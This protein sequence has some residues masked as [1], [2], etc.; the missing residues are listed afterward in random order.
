[1][2]GFSPCRL[3]NHIDEALLNGI[4]TSC[5]FLFVSLAYSFLYLSVIEF[6]L[7]CVPSFLCAFFFVCLSVS[8]EYRIDSAERIT[9]FLFVSCC[10]SPLE[11]QWVKS[12]LCVYS[13]GNPRSAL[14]VH[15][16]IQ[17]PLGVSIDRKYLT[18]P[19]SLINE[20]TELIKCT[21][22]PP[23]PAPLCPQT[24]TK[25]W[26]YRMDSNSVT[27]NLKYVTTTRRPKLTIKSILNLD[28]ITPI[29]I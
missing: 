5:L 6:F 3:V 14:C 26:T 9:D 1:M 22:H 11:P 29:K 2:C 13:F 7:F 25:C 4:G 21:P 19:G 16:V 17:D 8:E 10:F 12:A 24:I 23:P 15:L 27:H 20:Q 18:P 28:K